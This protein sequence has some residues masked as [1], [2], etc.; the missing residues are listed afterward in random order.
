MLRIHF[1]YY[2]IY[3]IILIIVVK[4]IRISAILNECKHSKKL[5]LQ[6]L[7]PIKIHMFLVLLLHLYILDIFNLHR[8]IKEFQ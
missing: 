7:L 2:T 4:I 3:F 5:H 1:N 8:I 6:N